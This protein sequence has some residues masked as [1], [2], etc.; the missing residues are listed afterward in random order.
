MIDPRR[1]E[2]PMAVLDFILMV[3]KIDEALERDEELFNDLDEA[4]NFPHMLLVLGDLY[5]IS[6]NRVS[7]QALNLI[8][9]VIEMYDKS[10]NEDWW[11]IVGIADPIFD[12]ARTTKE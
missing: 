4:K 11:L 5:R 2:Y 7:A 6:G 9:D 12:Q 8:W 3:E 10:D 1:V